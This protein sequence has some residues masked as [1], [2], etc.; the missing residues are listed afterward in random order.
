MN[1]IK[2]TLVFLTLCLGS[3]IYG[4]QF[5]QC[6]TDCEALIPRIE[7]NKEYIKNNPVA[8]RSG[9]PLYA[10]LTFHRVG[11]TEGTDYI[12]M[13]SILDNFCRLGRDYSTYTDIVPYINGFNDLPSSTVGNNPGSSSAISFMNNVFE[14]NS[15][16]VFISQDI[17]S[18][19]S[20]GTVLG[21]YAPAQDWLV[22]RQ[23]EVIDSSATLSHE[24]GH[25]FSLAHP[26]FGWE[27]QAYSIEDHGNPVI[28]TNHPISGREI[29]LVDR[30][31]N[32]ET[33]AD[34]LCDTP[35]SYLF[36]FGSDS[37]TSISGCSLGGNIFD[38]SGDKL[39][40]MADNMMDYF[41][42]C[43]QYVFTEQQAEVMHADFASPSRSY[44][45]SSHI[46]NTNE[47]TETTEIIFPT[48]GDVVEAY[49]SIFFE[50]TAVENADMYL[51]EIQDVF[52]GVRRE[53]IVN[54]NSFW[55]TELEPDTKYAWLVHPFN[56]TSACF[57]S[58]KKIF[59]T[60]SSITSTDEIDGINTVELYPNP[61]GVSDLVSLAIDSDSNFDVQI[62]ILSTNGQVLN[63]QVEQLISGANSIGLNVPQTPGVYVINVQ[64]ENGVISKRVIR[65]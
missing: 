38:S 49:N 2:T 47:I 4:Q 37:S 19:G 46:P 39:E 56:E 44:I 48:T 41:V 6:S 18:D 21:Y 61:S 53:Y 58:S 25:Y 17:N 65:Q 28:A 3:A 51:V 52:Q 60:G 45:R 20:V 32:C 23:T 54:T 29:E 55:A 14:D 64:H 11:T 24:V 30:S 1:I 50:W 9:D 22:M 42:G 63:T 8:L 31:K 12:P 10:P 26:F 33:T 27:S 62:S 59:D 5:H 36:G 43:D 57:K 40:P 34:R 15:V 7:A 35:A 16:N 13:T